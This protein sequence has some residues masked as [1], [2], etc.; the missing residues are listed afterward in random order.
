MVGPPTAPPLLPSLSPSYHRLTPPPS[1]FTIASH[2][3]DL[4]KAFVTHYYTTIVSNRAALQ[5]LY[6][7]ASSSLPY[8][9]P[10]CRSVWC[11]RAAATPPLPHPPHPPT[12]TTTS[13]APTTLPSSLQTP[14]VVLY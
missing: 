3:A 6:V 11:V 5:S 12:H 13:S 1:T 8:A 2:Q 9:V 7:R 14:R 10:R 4:G